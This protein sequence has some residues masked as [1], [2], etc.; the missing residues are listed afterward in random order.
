MAG[1]VQQR[2]HRRV[3]AC[4]NPGCDYAGFG[5]APEAAG[6]RLMVFDAYQFEPAPREQGG[7]RV[8]TDVGK[9]KDV[10]GQRAFIPPRLRR[11]PLPVE[12]GVVFIPLRTEGRSESERARSATRGMALGGHCRPGRPFLSRWCQLR[13]PVPA[14]QPTVPA[15]RLRCCVPR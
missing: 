1:F 9:T 12:G 6:N 5:L 2:V 8:E 4:V 11:D 7:R 3:G 13:L 10:V 14:T 15:L